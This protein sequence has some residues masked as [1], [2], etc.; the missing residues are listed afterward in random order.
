MER[1]FYRFGGELSYVQVK[2]GDRVLGVDKRLML[3]IPTPRGHVESSVVG[4]EEVVAK[5]L[6]VNVHIVLDRVRALTR[7]DKVGR[8]GVFLKCELAP[9]E[10]FES[11]L[12]EL[13]T[14][15]PAIR[16]RLR[17]STYA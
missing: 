16:R 2:H 3:I 12:N 13:A 15:N 8:T 14:K 6:N 11:S 9:D 1:E 5:L 4:Q 7:R 10:S 17:A